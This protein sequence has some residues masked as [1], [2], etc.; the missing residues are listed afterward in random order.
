MKLIQPM[1]VLLPIV[2]LGL[3][4]RARPETRRTIT[5]AAM[6]PMIFLSLGRWFYWAQHGTLL[7]GRLIS[8]LIILF[9]AT[10][11]Y[12]WLRATPKPSIHPPILVLAV[13]LVVS[14]LRH[15]YSPPIVILLANL[16]AIMAH[17]RSPISAPEVHRK[18]PVVKRPLQNLSAS[19]IVPAS[20]LG[21][22][23]VVAAVYIPVGAHRS[24]S[25]SGGAATGI[26]AT[27]LIWQLLLMMMSGQSSV[28]GDS[29]NTAK[30]SE[31]MTW[32]LQRQIRM[33][34]VVTIFLALFCLRFYVQLSPFVLSVFM[35]LAS[36]TFIVAGSLMLMERSVVGLLSLME[37]FWFGVLLAAFSMP[38]WHARVSP[39][40]ILV[41]LAVEMTADCW[42]LS[43]LTASMDRRL[44]LDSI[45]GWRFHHPWRAATLALLIL[46][47]QFLPAMPGFHFLIPILFTLVGRQA[48]LDVLILAAGGAMLVTAFRIL[49]A[50]YAKPSQLKI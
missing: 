43:A 37:Y 9:S 40:A 29:T 3:L 2:L 5:V 26:V 4:R 50:M 45:I 48:W 41:T 38:N 49:G 14:L 28:P 20:I 19:L 32:L 7:D 31:D 25:S 13:A 44:D 10:F 27:A 17:R 11:V 6:L 8:I 15:V 33:V 39:E 30:V 1:T 47:M 34:A 22:I 21:M 36:A 12:G 16:P 23:S 18:E 35:V 24:L 42:V 46:A